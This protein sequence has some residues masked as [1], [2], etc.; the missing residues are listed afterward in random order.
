LPP[1]KNAAFV[2]DDDGA[3][4]D[5]QDNILQSSASGMVSIRSARGAR[6]RIARR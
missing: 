6:T 2:E 1:A 3:G 4:Q 5:Q